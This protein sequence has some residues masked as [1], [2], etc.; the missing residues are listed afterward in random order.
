MHVF[1]CMLYSLSSTV[2]SKPPATSGPLKEQ[3][4]LAAIGQA[5]TATAQAT[6][7][8]TS[9]SDIELALSDEDHEHLFRRVRNASARWRNIGS[10]LGFTHGQLEDIVQ[11]RALH[12]NEHYMCELLSRWLR[13]APPNHSWP[14]KEDLATALRSV[15]EERVAYF[16]MKS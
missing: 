9:T 8:A 3:P 7:P 11:T 1:I 2:L 5:A 10:A 12:T 6:E 15:G 14:C 16:L 13:W 4:K